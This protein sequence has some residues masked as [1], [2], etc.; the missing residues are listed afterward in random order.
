MGAAKRDPALLQATLDAVAQHGSVAGAAMALGIAYGTF[1][2][3]HTAAVAWDAKNGGAGFS[4]DAPPVDVLSADELLARRKQIYDQKHDA[5]E[6]RR[7]IKVRVHVEGPYGIAHFG[8]PHLDDNGTN[9]A[10]I[11]RHIALIKKTEGLFGAS[12]GDY[13]NNWVGRLARLYA[14]QSTSAKEAWVLAEW[15]IQSV[16]WLYLVGGNH[17]A[18]SG[19]GDPLEWISTQA[20]VLYEA[21][22]V[23]LSL[24]SPN[25]HEVRVNARHDFKG[26]SMW[27]TAHGVAKAVQLGWR[28][29]ILTCGHLHTSGYQVLRDPATRLISHA[30]RV[31][32]YKFYDNYAI[33]KGLP[34]QTVFVCPVT[35]IDPDRDETDPRHITMIFDPEEGAEFLKWKRARWKKGKA[36]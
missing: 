15:F 2:H 1:Q 29:H 6:A 4:L 5:R 21:H 30:I 18:W 20:N 22:G 33:A 16:P 10:L 35:I 13:T 31:G 14:D 12:V 7:L 11:E 28:D 23:R 17:D 3:R 27:N 19:A 32:A 34:D 25:G 8:D 24:K 9:I 36:A 26:H